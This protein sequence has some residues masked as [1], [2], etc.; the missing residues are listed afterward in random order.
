MFRMRHVWEGTRRHGALAR[1]LLEQGVAPHGLVEEL[2]PRLLTFGPFS[3]AVK[4]P[5]D[6]FGDGNELVGG[7]PLVQDFGRG[8]L[9]TKPTG[10]E[11]FE[12]ELARVVHGGE[13]AQIVHHAESSVFV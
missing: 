9:G 4:H 12:S 11:K 5:E 1:N 6:G 13:H 2:E 10:H 7:H 3:V 8:R